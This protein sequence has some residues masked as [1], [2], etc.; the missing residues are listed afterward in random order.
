[1][2]YAPRG[3]K[4]TNDDDDDDDKRKCRPVSPSAI[5]NAKLFRICNLLVSPAIACIL[6]RILVMHRTDLN[7]Y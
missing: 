4:G 5:C 2:S 1:M 6:D 3:V 7:I